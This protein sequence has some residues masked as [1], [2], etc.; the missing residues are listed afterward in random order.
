MILRVALP[1]LIA[2]H[3]WS[4]RLSTLLRNTGLGNKKT[5]TADPYEWEL[6]S[7][8]VSGNSCFSLSENVPT[9][10]KLLTVRD[11]SCVG[12]SEESKKCRS[13][14]PFYRFLGGPSN[15]VDCL[16]AGRCQMMCLSKGLDA[17]ALIL[18]RTTHNPVECRCGATKKNL[19]IWGILKSASDDGQINFGPVHS[20]LPPTVNSAIPSDDTRCAMYMYVY[21]DAREDDGGV[22]DQFVD[23]TADD[24]TYI[25]SIVSGVEG[26]NDVEDSGKD[27]AVLI[28]KAMHDRLQLWLSAN[29]SNKYPID[30][31]FVEQISTLDTAAGQDPKCKDVD[32]PPNCADDALQSVLNVN[33]IKM[34]DFV[35]GSGY[36]YTPAYANLLMT[37][38]Y[39]QLLS[40]YQGATQP[41]TAGGF[42]Y[43]SSGFC[44]SPTI[45]QKCRITC[46]VCESYDRPAKVATK[47]N[48]WMRNKNPTTG[49]ITIPILMNKNNPLVTSALQT[50]VL[51]AAAIVGQVSCV[52]FTGVDSVGPNDLYVNVTV[53]VGPDGK[54]SGCMADPP[55]LAES[56][57]TPI[58][59]TIG[60]CSF[61]S[62][63]LG[64]LVHELLH[65]LSLVHTQ[66]RSDRDDYIQMNPI[67]VKKFFEANF[68]LEP[69]SF[70]GSDG[71]Y[72]PYDY[73]SIMHYTRTQAADV[74]QYKANP[75]LGGTFSL[76]KPLQNGVT[77][78]QR[79]AMS[80]LDISEVNTV[81]M[82]G[83]VIASN[84][85]T[86]WTV[87]GGSSSTTVP[88]S[89]GSITTTTTTQPPSTSGTKNAW[90]GWGK[91]IET[92]ADAIDSVLTNSQINLN[93]KQTDALEGMIET[94]K[95]L[96]DVFNNAIT[97]QNLKLGWRELIVSFA[98]SVLAIIGESRN[99]I[100]QFDAGK[101][102]DQSG[103]LDMAAISQLEKVIKTTVSLYSKLDT[104]AKTLPGAISMHEKVDKKHPSV[105]GPVTVYGGNSHRR[106]RYRS[107]IPQA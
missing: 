86:F 16:D 32:E 17:A 93:E 60:G 59:L 33:N 68:F 44:S 72:S 45:L 53:D 13:G 8:P 28:N 77:L 97:K 4:L 70:V 7:N 51:Q 87:S 54:P 19:S 6:V 22:P 58:T 106:P 15:C 66:M 3:V 96:Y 69:Y 61:N 41:I 98:K 76:L 71:N 47:Y 74:T 62:K 88:R 23:I 10:E 85:A 100:T 27:F 36:D 40:L 89:A 84:P 81:N 14:F 79:T 67:I 90:D 25:R 83:G 18:D 43:R 104:Y 5:A 2:G 38:P 49:V 12:F 11:S 39:K 29:P 92:I 73:G 52:N 48:T 9:T 103:I 46:G 78:G 30:E 105:E 95:K 80:N 82:C 57:S 20:L 1:L 50:L 56:P 94:Q 99:G 31:I 101:N 75:Q 24:E 42:S 21:K 26:L 37:V 64:S 55:G 102:E 65:V 34:G 35:D 63:P 91:D 107:R